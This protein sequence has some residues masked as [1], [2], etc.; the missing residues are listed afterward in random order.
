MVCLIVTSL[1]VLRLKIKD[2]LTD[3]YMKG[4]RFTSCLIVCVLLAA[5][6]ALRAQTAQTNPPLQIMQ[7]RLHDQPPAQSPAVSGVSI[8]GPYGVLTEEQRTSYRALMKAASGQLMELN[9]KLVAAN[10]DI[11]VT[12]VTGTFDE[13]LMHEKAL[14]AARIQADMVVLRAKIFSEVQPPLTPEQA[15]KIK[16]GQTAPPRPT[17][18]P[19]LRREPPTAVTNN[20][21]NGLLPKP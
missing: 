12:S 19:L 1:V 15:E 14:V 2:L 6:S 18:Q 9:S 17:Q 21:P 20:D 10:H 8:G 13:N 11:L 16:S 5:A 7:Q 3:N 4:M